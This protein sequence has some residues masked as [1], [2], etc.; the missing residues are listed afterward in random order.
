MGFLA[1][2]QFVELVYKDLASKRTARGRKG[3]R[4]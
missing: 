1:P 4:R 3:Q 2:D